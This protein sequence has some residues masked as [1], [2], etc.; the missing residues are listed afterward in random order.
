M[1][2]VLSGRG[3]C[4]TDE[5]KNEVAVWFSHPA[6]ITSKVHLL[7]KTRAKSVW[8]VFFI[9][10][11]PILSPAKTKRK[12]LLFALVFT[13][14]MAAAS[15]VLCRYLGFSPEN[16]AFRF[17]LGFLPLAFV[18][19]WLGPI[20][21]GA[22]YLLADIVGSLLS[23]YAPNLWISG[24]KLLFGIGMGLFFYKKKPS[25]LRITVAFLI[26][27]VLVD[28]VL[29]TPIFIF[30]Y[31]Y[32]PDE[33]YLMRAI[34]IAVTLP[35]RV[36]SFYFI[37]SAVREPMRRVAKGRFTVAADSNFAKFANSFQAVTVPGLT[38]IALLSQ[39]LGSP[40]KRLRF[41]HIAGT[42]GKGSVAAYTASILE[43]AGFCVGKYT[44]P[45]LLSVNERVSVNGTPISD[46]ALK[47][48]LSEI[49]PLSLEV[50]KE[51]GLAPTQFEIWTAMAFVY[52]AK[53]QCDYVVLEVG[54]GGELDATNVIERNEIA[55]ITRLGLDHTQYLGKTLAEVAKAKCGILKRNSATHTVVTVMQEKEAMRV[56]NE[57]AEEQGLSV[58]TVS[59]TIY[60]CDGIYERFTLPDFPALTTCGLSGVHQPENAALAATVAK[61]LGVSYEDILYG[62]KNAVHPARFELIRK[63]PTVIF[64]G[65]HNPNGIEAAVASLHR[66]FGKVKKTVIFACMADKEIA[67]SLALLSEGETEFVFT[68]VKDN[69]RAMTASD[70]LLRAKGD[71]F[72]GV[73]FEE[74]RDAYQYA[75]EKGDL[76]LICVSLYLYKDLYDEILSKNLI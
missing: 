18:G 72:D 10:Q 37:E 53:K 1:R 58:V 74:L 60:D 59:P 14:A 29:M 66:Y 56:I 6:V 65:G 69:P 21:S 41:I 55:V 26:I 68:T 63:D 25:F 19:A 50:E 51:T 64:D 46:E 23:G 22:G 40:E 36:V 35:I 61:E 62:I 5:N 9:L 20:Y 43:K 48:I 57:K 31:G 39:K 47:D 54:L 45:N 33:A 34:N 16:S 52:F 27:N 13:A 2:Q 11:N 76:V 32:T 30:M 71:G 8:E 12:D 24:C 73:A 70:L 49:E 44:S 38:R 15:V 3:V 7:V 75:K 17:D 42:N 28:F 4:P 67:P